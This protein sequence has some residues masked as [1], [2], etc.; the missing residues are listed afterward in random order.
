MFFD[1]SPQKNVKSHVFGFWKK[2]EKNVLS[3]YGSQQPK[4]IPS[5]KKKCPKSGIFF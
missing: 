2:N 1:M 3:N 5:S 4:F